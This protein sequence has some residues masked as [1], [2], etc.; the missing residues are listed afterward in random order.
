MKNQK[1]ST[2]LPQILFT[3]EGME[4]IQ[5]RFNYLTEYRQEVL[6][7]LQAA[8][9]M[10][11]L[12]EN[13]AYKAAR[14]E[15]SDTDRELKRLRYQLRFGTVAEISKD[16]KVGFGN[17]VTID[18]GNKEITFSLVSKYESDPKQR[19]LSIK[20]P[21]GEAVMG[22]KV[23]D[24]VMVKAPNGDKEYKIVKVE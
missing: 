8:R 3:K 1:V 4:K 23:G 24:E 21:F 19:K 20:S 11:D 16:G 9:E 14:F 13:G 18:D 6:V 15:L 17:T 22:K 12:S 10:G 7:R 5:E 2:R